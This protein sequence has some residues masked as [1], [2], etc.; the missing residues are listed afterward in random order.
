MV[1]ET[2]VPQ[3]LLVFEKTN[4]YLKNEDPKVQQIAVNQNRKRLKIGSKIELERGDLI[5]ITVMLPKNKILISVSR[6]YG[7]GKF[8]E[9]FFKITEADYESLKA[10]RD[11]SLGEEES[12]IVRKNI[13][14]ALRAAC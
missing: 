8:D 7:F 1:R 10:E 3:R 11:F 9:K 2:I 5:I 4:A 13:S 14:A 12:K 6:Y